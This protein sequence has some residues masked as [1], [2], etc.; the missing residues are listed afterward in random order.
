M[1]TYTVITYGRGHILRLE[2]LGIVLE[3][4]SLGSD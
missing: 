4:N 2:Y 3:I 1:Y